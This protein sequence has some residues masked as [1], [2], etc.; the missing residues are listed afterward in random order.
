MKRVRPVLF[1]LFLTFFFASC[2][3]GGEI[4]TCRVSVYGINGA[5]VLEETEMSCKAGD[6]A[7]D[8]LKNA[9]RGEKIH[10]EFSGT[11][12]AA[13]VK[14]IDNIYEFDMGPD[15]GWI[16][17]VNGEKPGVGCGSYNV[18]EGDSIRWEYIT[19]E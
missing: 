2:A 7:L 11:G 8:V 13:Y 6:T 12:A 1:F 10:M 15:S 18:G 4:I 16:Y 3:N 17:Y 19:E 5:V 14:G 9:T